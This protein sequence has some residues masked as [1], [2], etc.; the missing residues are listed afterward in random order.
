MAEDKKISEAVGLLLK[1]AKMLSHHCPS[2]YLPLFQQDE[3]V[4]C[5]HCKREFTLV[6]D[7]GKVTI[8]AVNGEK[9]NGES[10]TSE[11]E[12]KS[13]GRG[14]ADEI[15]EDTIASVEIL[16]RELAERA[17]GS[18]SIAEIRE[19]VHVMKE[20]AEIYRMLKNL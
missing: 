13:E 10:A 8:I 14:A 5:P 11:A 16:L 12:S 3:R 15:A 17:R 6:E 1:G 4:F 7:G 20:L 2:C 19:I 9:E 18:E